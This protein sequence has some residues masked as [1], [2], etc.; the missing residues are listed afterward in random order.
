MAKKIKEV[1]KSPLRSSEEFR[2]LADYLYYLR[3]LRDM[4]MRDVEEEARRLFKKGKIKKDGLVSYA[5][6][7][8]IESRRVSSPS[9]V[10]L[11]TLALIFNVDHEM[12]LEKAGYLDKKRSKI[13][14]D[15]AFTLM[16]KEVPR[17]TDDEKQSLLDYIDFVKSR[18]KK[19]EKG[20]KKG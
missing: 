5:Y 2:D 18:R 14:E 1:K 11:G 19:Y 8:N 12:V 9:P 16:L 10:I 20:P 7:S 4:S 6:I 13:E 3:T 15:V 17:M